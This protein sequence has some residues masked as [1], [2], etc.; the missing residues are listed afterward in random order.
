MNAGIPED[1]EL[2]YESG[3]K[4]FAGNAPEADIASSGDT[5]EKEYT[6]V[7]KAVLTAMEVSE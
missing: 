1:A 2:D 3:V 4:R 5:L 7:G 6:I